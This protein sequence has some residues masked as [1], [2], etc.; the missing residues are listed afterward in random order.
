MRMMMKIAIPVEAGNIAVKDGSLGKV[1][2]E[3][4]ERLKPEAAYFLPDNGVRTG[5]MV[6]DVKDASDIPSLAEPF[7]MAFNASITMVP[8]M[9]ADDLKAGLAKLS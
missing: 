1:F 6:F 5:I 2:G 9:N 3:A 7:F 8:V 4:L